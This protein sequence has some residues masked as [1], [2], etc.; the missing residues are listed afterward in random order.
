MYSSGSLTTAFLIALEQVGAD[1]RAVL[2]QIIDNLTS[3]ANPDENF[4]SLNKESSK[5]SLK[6]GRVQENGNKKADDVTK[7][8]AVLIIGAGRVCRP[9]AELLASVGSDCEW[10]KSCMDTAGEEQNDIQV[11]VASLYLKDAEEV[12]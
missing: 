11:I 7:Q 12:Q 6:L 9:A 10:Y 5:L 4:G 2:D 3:L 8:S 1:D